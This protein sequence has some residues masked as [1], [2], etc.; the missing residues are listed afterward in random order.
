MA[1]IIDV[2]SRFI[3][4]WQASTSLRSDLAIDALEMAIY[5]RNEYDLTNLVHHSDRGA[6]SVNPLLRATGRS[7]DRRVR[8]I[9]GDQPLK[10]IDR[11]PPLH[12]SKSEY[13]TT[14][15]FWEHDTI[16]ENQQFLAMT[17]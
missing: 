6:I 12:I 5:A 7:R 9:E 11:Q 15:H 10:V 4:R 1:F 17:S 3:V 16:G 13:L 8:W 14:L 2:F